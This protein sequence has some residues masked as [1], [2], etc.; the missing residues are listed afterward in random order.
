VPLR[1]DRHGHNPWRELAAL[2]EIIGIY[3]RLRPDLAHHVAIKPVLYG[4][5]AARLAGT[6]L[7]V[8]AIAGLGYVTSSND[9]RARL[10]RPAIAAAYRLLVN[11]NGSR[12][13]VQNPDDVEA[14]TQRH[15]IDRERVTLIRGS[16][17]DTQ[18]FSPTMAQKG[19][20]LVVVAARLVRDKGVVEF[21]EAA[22]LLRARGVNARFA[23]VGEPDPSHPAQIAAGELERWRGE[24]VI[25]YWGWREDMREVYRQAHLVCLPSY[26]EGLPK[27]LIEA[28]AC[29][30]AIVTCDVP[31]CREVV[32]DGD[33]GLLVPPRT[34]EP[35][36]QALGRL[37]GDADLRARM[38]M[39]SR[40]RAVAEFSIE[41]VV[42]DT[43]ALYRAALSG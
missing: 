41:R 38:G 18:Q 34:V 31:G 16:G 24:G 17:V 20:C 28:A 5:V 23:L 21:V 42:A 43:L 9:L 3:R 39:R 40:E 26:R 37:I 29:G 35:L 6:P 7:V 25:E 14:L 33:N 30:L 22:R 12:L 13:I 8:N 32:R 10:L 2:R 1:L 11:R 36:A 4:S 19:P 15:I 27:A